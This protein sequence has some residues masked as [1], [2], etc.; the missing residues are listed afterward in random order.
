MVSNKDI[1][2]TIQNRRAIRKYK[3][4]PVPREQIDKILEAGRWA[5]SGLNNQPW[6]VMV[7]SDEAKKNEL[8]SFTKYDKIIKSAPLAICVFLDNSKIYSRDK[9]L[10][11]IGAFIQNMWLEAHSLGLGCCWLGEILNQKEKVHK[12][13]KLDKDLELAAVLT[14]GFPDQTPKGSRKEIEDILIKLKY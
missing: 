9:D 10:M 1:L 6:K 12:F 5:P 13:L 8:A 4:K 3:D 2:Q 7:I 14:V 11:A